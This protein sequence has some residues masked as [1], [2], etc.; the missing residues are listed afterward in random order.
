MEKPRLERGAVITLGQ[1][2]YE[3]VAIRYDVRG[4]FED[5]W[6]WARCRQ[7][8]KLGQLSAGHFRES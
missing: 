2:D 6:V 4:R 5:T 7:D 1:F 3:V 8:G